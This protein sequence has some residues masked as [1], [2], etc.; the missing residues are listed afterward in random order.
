MA[1]IDDVLKAIEILSTNVDQIA[2]VVRKIDEQ[3]ND[4][5]PIK[6]ECDS[7][8]ATLALKETIKSVCGMCQG[9]GIRRAGMYDPITGLPY[10]ADITC[11]TCSGTGLVVTGESNE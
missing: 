10:D 2:E 6:A 9:T 3:C 1:D 7:I 11:V 5:D 8:I 4:I